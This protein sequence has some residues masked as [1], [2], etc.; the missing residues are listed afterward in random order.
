MEKEYFEIILEDINSKF[1]LVLENFQSL[2]AKMEEYNLDSI[3]RDE[4]KIKLLKLAKEDSDRRNDETN[5]LLKL[6]KEELY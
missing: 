2:R 4:E 6:T 5:Q 3:S 1:N